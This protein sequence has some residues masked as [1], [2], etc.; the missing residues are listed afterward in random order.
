M[1]R[2][3]GVAAKVL[4]LSALWALPAA[5]GPSPA[6]PPCVRV[7]YV[8]SNRSRMLYRARLFGHFERA[9]VRVE[10]WT[11]F[12]RAE[13]LV[14]I[15]RSH[16]GYLALRR[17]EPGLGR[18]GKFTG[19]EAVSRMLEGQWDAAVVGEASFLVSA[20]RGSPIVA[21]A[22]LGHDVA[23]YPGYS[24]LLSTRVVIRGPADFRGKRLVSRRAGP[25]DEIFLREFLESVGLAG[26]PA[27]RV[28]HQVPDE[29]VLRLLPEGEIDGGLYHLKDE[30]KLTESG[31]AYRFRGMDWVD[32]ELPHALLVFPRDFPAA[33]PDA[34]GRL[35][36][37]YLS[38]I[39]LERSREHRPRWRPVEN[40]ADPGLGIERAIKSMS[41]PVHE[42]R[43]VPSYDL[44]P[45]VRPELLRRMQDL[46]LKHG[47]ID[48]KVRLDEY[49]DNRFVQE[50]YRRLKSSGAGSTDEE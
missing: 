2:P 20:H 25:S 27:V 39:A 48:R 8:D 29:D 44:P 21:V 50:A 38:R 1:I 19:I 13:G 35:L 16:E 43:R 14:R 3:R 33:N 18:L 6:E 11:R 32:P 40:A 26:D 17:R 30:I 41:H 42:G 9:G 34:V 24:I 22:M 12:S 28:R 5:A 37:G 45:L 46:L 49:V 31:A 4:C 10:L 15:P 7:G 23:D 36:D 47:R